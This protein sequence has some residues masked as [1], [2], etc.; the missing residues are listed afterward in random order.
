[1]EAETTRVM[2]DSRHGE[3][4]SGRRRRDKEGRK[5][6]G[7]GK[8]GGGGGVVRAWIFAYKFGSVSNVGHDSFAT[9]PVF[10]RHIFVVSVRGWCCNL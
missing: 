5:N 10:V 1:M 8:A 4:V 2:R 6:G 3:A 7:R 9:Q